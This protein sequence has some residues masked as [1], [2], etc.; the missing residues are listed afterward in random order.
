[1]P[2]PCCSCDTADAA[3]RAI[4]HHECLLVFLCF[5]YR[6][7]AL[8]MFF[9]CCPLFLLR[10]TKVSVVLPSLGRRVHPH[11][12][13]LSRCIFVY[14][15]GRQLALP[16]TPGGSAARWCSSF[17]PCSSSTPARNHNRAQHS[18]PGPYQVLEPAIQR[19]SV[20]VAP[21][22][23]L[24]VLCLLPLFPPPLAAPLLPAALFAAAATRIPALPLPPPPAL[25]PAF[26]LRIAATAV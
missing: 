20:P 8:F 26:L 11:N 24:C 13:F 1:M 19:G 17:I 3:W 9:I 6:Q 7:I 23:V 2:L 22:L 14:N 16:G 10:A 12:S 4:S 18:A 25:L 15:Q 21:L 5:I